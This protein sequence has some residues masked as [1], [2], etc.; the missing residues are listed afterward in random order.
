MVQGAVLLKQLVVDLPVLG[1]PPIKIERL[2][3]R[4]QLYGGVTIGPTI[5]T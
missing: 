1:H 4:L 2:G 3:L 5:K